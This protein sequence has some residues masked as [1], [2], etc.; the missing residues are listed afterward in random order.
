[1]TAPTST[2]GTPTTVPVP[3]SPPAA[4]TLAVSSP[5]KLAVTGQAEGGP[6]PAALR[7]LERLRRPGAGRT[8]RGHILVSP[9]GWVGSEGKNRLRR[10]YGG[11]VTVTSAQLLSGFPAQG[12]PGGAL[13]AG[14][15]GARGAGSAIDR[16]R[17]TDRP[18]SSLAITLPVGERLIDG[19]EVI[20]IGSPWDGG[21]IDASTSPRVP[22]ALGGLILIFV[23]VQWLIDRRDPKLVEAPASRHEDSIGFE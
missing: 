19:Q 23:F 14:A 5:A 9:Q 11:Q 6:A 20:S 3:P 8:S 17:P 7:A 2:T 22:F 13:G 18:A 16:L 1:V 12:G 21:S 15:A 10:P 4:A